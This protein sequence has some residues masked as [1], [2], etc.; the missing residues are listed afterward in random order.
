MWREVFSRYSSSRDEIQETDAVNLVLDMFAVHQQAITQEMEG[1]EA[2][3]RMRTADTECRGS[4]NFFEFVEYSRGREAL[5][6]RLG[7]AGGHVQRAERGKHAVG[8]CDDGAGARG[9][10]DEGAGGAG[11]GA[12]GHVQRAG[13]GKLVVGCLCIFPSFRPWSRMAMGAYSGAATG[14]PG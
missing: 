14:I 2:V 7:G 1:A 5:F 4:I 13:C 12:G 9:G 8:V 6:G 11:G 3:E 10:D